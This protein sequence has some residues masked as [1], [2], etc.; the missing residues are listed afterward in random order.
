MPGGA[1]I[2]PASRYAARDE[3]ARATALIAVQPG[4]GAPAT[5]SRL[6]GVRGSCS[7][8]SATGSTLGSTTV[9]RRARLLAGGSAVA[10][11]STVS[12]V[13]QLNAKSTKRLKA[14]VD[15]WAA[16]TR[17]LIGAEGVCAVDAE[18]GAVIDASNDPYRRKRVEGTL[19]RWV[20]KRAREVCGR[21]DYE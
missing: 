14:Q 2:D 21:S 10:T 8:A 4:L 1:S 9:G 11:A 20:A 12:G 17:L 18:T 6:I 5:N 13:T 3:P 16:E 19:D 15:A 7:R